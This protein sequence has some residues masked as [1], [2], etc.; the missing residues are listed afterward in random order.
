MELPFAIDWKNDEIDIESYMKAQEEIENLKI[1]IPIKELQKFFSDYSLLTKFLLKFNLLTFNR[2]L[3]LK[4]ELDWRII[5]QDFQL[6][7][8]Q[9]LLVESYLLVDNLHVDTYKYFTL[10]LF[11]KYKEQINWTRASYHMR[12]FKFLTEF[13]EKL[14]WKV[15]TMNWNLSEEEIEIFSDKLDWNYI[16]M[17]GMFGS[18][19]L[20]KEFQEK[21]I[22]KI[23][24]T[25]KSTQDLDKNI[26]KDAIDRIIS[27][28]LSR[29]NKRIVN[30]NNKISFIDEK[31]T[32]DDM[33]EIEQINLENLSKIFQS[34]YEN[35]NKEFTDVKPKQ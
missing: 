4:D 24:P 27:N 16:S 25:F 14:D 33:K 26:H 2:I 28:G 19:F 9:I 5:G 17:Y 13:K 3:L 23:N 20:S 6:N 1:E 22:M 15:V 7:L 30:T 31:A 18:K 32:L 10:E 21:H 34:Y 8:D 35:K 12:D 29:N 11:R